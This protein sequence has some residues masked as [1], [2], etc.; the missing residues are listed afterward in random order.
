MLTEW[1]DLTAR[2]Q[3]AQAEA[4]A[5]F[6]HAGQCHGE[7]VVRLAE[8]GWGAPRVAAVASD[9]WIQWEGGDCPLPAL[10]HVDVEL[11][12]GGVYISGD[13]QHYTADDWE[14]K[15]EVGSHAVNV[16]AYRI[17]PSTQQ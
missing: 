16:V 11:G 3:A 15:H 4:D 5:L 9:T 17:T 10:T 12:D 6:E 1:R 8:L 13:T 2:A 14:W 7:I